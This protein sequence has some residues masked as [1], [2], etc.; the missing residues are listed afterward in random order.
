MKQKREQNTLTQRLMA[1]YLAVIAGISCIACYFAY[2]QRRGE[3]LA[4]MDLALLQVENEYRSITENFWDI[5]IPIYQKNYSSEETL[6]RYFSQNDPLTPLDRGSLKELLAEMALRDDRIR[7]IAV[8]NAQRESNY[9]YSPLTDILDILPAGFPY[10]EALNNKTELLETYGTVEASF[11][12]YETIVMAGGDSMANPHNAIAVGYDT[13]GMRGICADNQITPSIRFDV[14]LDGTAIFSS[15]DTAMPLNCVPSPG[16]S[17][18]VNCNGTGYYVHASDYSARNARICYSVNHG[19]LLWLSHQNT[20]TILLLVA[21]V[22]AL[23]GAIY[24]VTMRSIRQEVSILRSGLKQIGENDLDYR[25]EADFRQGDFQ[26]IASSINTM[27]QSLKE[28]I[29]Q[30]YYYQLRQR[31]AELQE[32]QSKFN[33]HFLYNTLE[34]FRARC[35]QNGDVETAELITQTAAIFR[36]FISPR[37]FIPI[38][39]E[40][41]F[42]KRYLALFRARYGES[43]QILY[44]FDTDV[45][46]YGIIR[47]IFQP[48]IE[49]YF[50][51]GINTERKDNYIRFSGHIRDQD[52]FLVVVED[53]GLGMEPDKLRKLNESMARPIV[54]AEE[55]YGLKNLNQRLRLFYGEGCGLRLRLNDGGGLTQ[56]LV[57]GRWTMEDAKKNV[58]DKTTIL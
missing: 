27:A 45:L 16:G 24:I 15:T 39:E 46:Q 1:F 33:P 30:V 35:Y 17:G 7:W 58:P 53:N 8:I 19:E 48:L 32:L 31:E 28:K 13:A 56:E 50:V 12:G 6:Y 20:P 38:Q 34:M 3:L 11:G 22:T 23:S 21:I 29:D 57:V 4:R 47:N 2:Q 26:Q 44:D 18:T 5:Y 37:T 10:W 40:L 55:S 49:N 9:Y 51:H 54:T 14:I 36:G 43:L 41:A 42:S 52:T 25:I